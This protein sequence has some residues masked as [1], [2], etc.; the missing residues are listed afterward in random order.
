MSGYPGLGLVGF[1]SRISSLGM[2]SFL[3]SLLLARYSLMM[4]FV[5][6]R[7]S[8]TKVLTMGGLAVVV[9]LV[10]VVA[11]RG[12]LVVLRVVRLE[13]KEKCQGHTCMTRRWSY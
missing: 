5:S 4:S 11:G 8:E 9:A 1:S 6:G 2:N 13:M 7:S 12:F 3:P 10:V